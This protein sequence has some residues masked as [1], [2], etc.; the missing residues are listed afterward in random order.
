MAGL[1]RGGKA[2]TVVEGEQ[3]VV[4]RR[5]VG[6]EVRP[7]MDERRF[8]H[9]TKRCSPQL[10]QN[11]VKGCTALVQKGKLRQKP[12][13]PSNTPCGKRKRPY[14]TGISRPTLL[15]WLSSL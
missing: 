2:G 9:P 14:S 3:H 1:H 15:K 6:H 5:T 13:G 12:R 11:A 4:D 8:R 7:R 10:P